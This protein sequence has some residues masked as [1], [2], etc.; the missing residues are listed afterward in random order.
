M[1]LGLGAGGGGAVP[2]R[3]PKGRGRAA[4]REQIALLFLS[5]EEMPE[6][7]A[8]LP[9]ATWPPN[10]PHRLSSA[11]RAA[12]LA[13]IPAALCPP[14]CRCLAAPSVPR[15]WLCWAASRLQMRRTGAGATPVQKASHS[16]CCPPGFSPASWRE[17]SCLEPHFLA[18][19]ELKPMA[20]RHSFGISPLKLS[21]H[22]AS[23]PT[24]DG[25]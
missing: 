8:L 16:S 6:K 3:L 10:V 13:F 18:S 1:Y 5:P 7:R 24:E 9:D 14:S 11:G 20:K 22:S 25:R 12:R 19:R 17:L 23:A 21:Q 15:P 4:S 2:Q